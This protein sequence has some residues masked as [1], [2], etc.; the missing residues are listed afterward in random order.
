MTA[1]ATLVLLLSSALLASG[2]AARSAFD[3]EELSK[4]DLVGA[5]RGKVHFKSGPYASLTDLE[6]LYVFNAGGTMT[7]SSNYDGAPPVPPAYGIWRRIGPGEFEARYMFY[8]TRP[9]DSLNALAGGG[10]WMPAGHGLLVERI[11]LASDGKTFT[12]AMKYSA[13]D[14]Q[15]KPVEGGGDADVEAVRMEF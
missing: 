8:I 4:K 3:R 5:W 10:G 14:Q 7:E 6:F 2:S 15:G 12:S 13:F 1:T 11:T 9:P